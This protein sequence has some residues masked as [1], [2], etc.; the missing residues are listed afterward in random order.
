MAPKTVYFIE[1]VLG[2]KKKWVIRHIISIIQ[3][4]FLEHRFG[5]RLGTK[6]LRRIRCAQ[7]DIH[8]KINAQQINLGNNQIGIGKIGVVLIS[9]LA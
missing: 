4:I 5:K 9:I 3:T 6:D 8:I 7:R 2:V 1:D